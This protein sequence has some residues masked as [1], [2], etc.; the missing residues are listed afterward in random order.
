MPGRPAFRFLLSLLTAFTLLAAAAPLPASANGQV[1]ETGVDYTFG[2]AVSFRLRL[3]SDS[4]IQSATIFFQMAGSTHTETGEAEVTLGEGG[5]YDLRYVHDPN[6]WPIRAFSTVV[7]RFDILQQDGQSYRT[8]DYSFYYEDN[9]FQWQTLEEDEFVVHWYQGQVAFAQGVLDVAQAG[10]ER[11]QSLL[12]LPTPKKVQIYVYSSSSD[13][14]AIL[15]QS[16][17]NWVA[18]HA[19]PEL[20][21]MAV[22]LPAGP[23]QRL[24]M[25][26]RIPHELMHIMLYQTAGKAYANL[27]T[28]LSEGLASLAEL[29]PNPDYQILLNN[30]QE[31]DSLLP[32]ASLCK[33]FPM[34]ASNALLAYA[35]S[36][37]FTR[38]LE[39]TYG[40]D[41]LKN[42]TS[43]Y[44]GGMDCERGATSVFGQSLSQIERQWRQ[45]VFSENPVA[46]GLEK[47]GPWL[48]LMAAALAAPLGL[49]IALL[50]RRPAIQEV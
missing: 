15:S 4:P 31:R 43:A 5:E 1:E 23:D 16:G 36:A 20:G 35:Q 33:T 2:G 32:M 46:S 39:S 38:F 37:S 9:R 44:A 50:R 42:L 45:S 6:R 18:G 13:L 28:W 8:P 3:R 25:E 10:L 24:L 21:A 40:V 12:P 14:Q 41:G 22:S 34:D 30:A 49:I 26:Q 47:L 48:L 29:Y 17:P 27:P 7:Y 19:D 11:V